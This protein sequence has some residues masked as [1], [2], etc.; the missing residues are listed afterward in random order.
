MR[1]WSA[2]KKIECYVDILLHN[3]TKQRRMY[4]GEV[5]DIAS[6]AAILKPPDYEDIVEKMIDEEVV[7]NQENRMLC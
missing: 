1:R 3:Y 2:T 4:Q 5:T 6:K 7:C